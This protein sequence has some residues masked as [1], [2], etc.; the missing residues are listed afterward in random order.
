MTKN[1]LRQE[2]INKLQQKRWLRSAEIVSGK[3]ATD[4]AETFVDLILSEYEVIE[5]E[6]FDKDDLAIFIL[7]F[8][9]DECAD[10]AMDIPLLAAAIIKYL[11]DE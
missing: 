1:N 6:N 2:L 4:L 5:K 11:I 3:P 9:E 8:Y 10:D 7:H